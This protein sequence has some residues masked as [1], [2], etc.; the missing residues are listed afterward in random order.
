MLK[1]SKLI[2][3]CIVCLF[4]SSIYA[5]THVIKM[6]TNHT[7]SPV[8]EPS[9]LLIQPG[10]TVVWRNIDSNF[11]HNIVANPN[12]I[13][14][15]AS[16]FESPLLETVGKEWSHQFSQVGTYHYHCHPHASK[17]MKG[18]VVVGRESPMDKNRQVSGKEHIHHH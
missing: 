13:P 6:I 9:Y 1:I 15:G 10:D 17:G 12:G 18:T 2:L 3:P 11:S 14:E 8:F 7:G 5:Q 16:L 4:S